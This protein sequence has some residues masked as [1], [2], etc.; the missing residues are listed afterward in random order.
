MS[1]QTLNQYLPPFLIGKRT[2]TQCKTRSNSIFLTDLSGNCEE[3]DTGTGTSTSMMRGHHKSAGMLSQPNTIGVIGG[4]SVLSTLV[5]MEKL[6]CWG[7]RNGKE[8]PPF[9]VCSDPVLSKV[10]Q[11][12]SPFPSVKSRTNHIKLNQE[13]M[14]ENLRYK[15]NLLQ[16][17]GARVLAMPC[18]LSHAWHSEVSED[19]SLPFLHVGDCVAMELKNAKL[20]PIHAENTV[21][22][23]LLSTDSSFVASYYQDK[24]QSQVFLFSL[25]SDSK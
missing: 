12:R 17:S 10:P 3:S 23:G 7:T 18:H 20:K 6:A 2:Q 4:V 13:L 24:L 9:V 11:L 1:I 5:F 21:R 8:C 22:I 16:R 19:S 25:M 14:I 15:R